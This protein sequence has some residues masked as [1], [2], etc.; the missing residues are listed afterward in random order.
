MTDIKTQEEYEMIPQGWAVPI[1]DKLEYNTIV[2]I[3][4]YEGK[5]VF[6]SKKKQKISE[7]INLI[8]DK[9][10]CKLKEYLRLPF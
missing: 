2:T 7:S 1:L 8:S 5:W 9:I 3:A 4:Y 10:A 6:V